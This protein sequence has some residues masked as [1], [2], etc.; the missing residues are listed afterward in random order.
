M[1][2]AAASAVVDL[3]DHLVLVGIEPQ[4]VVADDSQL[5]R[6][7]SAAIELIQRVQQGAQTLACEQLTHE[8]D[9][10]WVVVGA[11]TG[12]LCDYDRVAD[13]GQTGAGEVPLHVPDTR[14]RQQHVL[15]GQAVEHGQTPLVEPTGTVGARCRHVRR[16]SVV[17]EHDRSAAQ[18]R[19]D[20]DPHLAPSDGPGFLHRVGVHDSTASGGPER[21]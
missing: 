6:A 16:G 11:R 7:D 8:E 17:V 10:G 2:A 5:V 14:R 21:G 20:R 4:G 13:D 3:F 19:G 18:A 9:H 15:R 12:H 1:S